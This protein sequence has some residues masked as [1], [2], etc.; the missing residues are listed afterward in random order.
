[1]LILH[2]VFARRAANQIVPNCNAQPPSATAEQTT[3]FAVERVPPSTTKR[4]CAMKIVSR[5]SFN[6]ARP[7]TSVS[8]CRK[9]VRHLP[10]RQ[11]EP[12]GTPKL[13][14]R[15]QLKAV[16]NLA[17]LP[18]KNWGVKPHAGRVRGQFGRRP[19]FTVAWGIVPR[20][21]YTSKGS[22]LASG[23]N[24]CQQRAVSAVR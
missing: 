23:P 13:L 11:P 9:S 17:T 24:V 2:G 21:F 8:A 7:S 4:T 20:S 14:S 3:P 6:E 12:C 5:T 16:R 15:N 22:F 19:F 1:M 18:A 10:Q